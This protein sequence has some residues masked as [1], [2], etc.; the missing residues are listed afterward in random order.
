MSSTVYM[1]DLSA[2]A[3]KSLPQ[4]VSELIEFLEPGNIFKPKDLVAVKIHFGEAGNTAYIRPPYVRRIVDRL[5]GSR[6]QAL[7]YR[8]KHPVRGN[9]D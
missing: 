4:K 3:R 7:P 6:N 9:T 1:T 2:D 8:H 5:K